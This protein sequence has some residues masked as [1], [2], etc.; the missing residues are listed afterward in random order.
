MRQWFLDPFLRA[1]RTDFQLPFSPEMG[2]KLL[3]RTLNDIGAKS[4]DRF[5]PVVV[6]MGHGATSMN[7]PFSAAYNCGTCNGHNGGPNA[8]LFSRLANHRAVRQHL[9]KVPHALCCI[10]T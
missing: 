2:A 3:A 9:S 8:R 4:P 5:A 1:P 7:N 10:L 6:V